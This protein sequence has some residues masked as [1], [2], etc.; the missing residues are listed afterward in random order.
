MSEKTRKEKVKEIFNDQ[1]I[2]L[3]ESDMENLGLAI[4]DTLRMIA[5][6]IEEKEPYAT[7]SI[8]RYREVASAI[9]GEILDEE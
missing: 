5:D 2:F 3:D 8:A 1:G 6:D 7:V 9:Q 4:E